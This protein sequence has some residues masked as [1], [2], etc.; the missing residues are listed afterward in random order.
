V[1]ENLEEDGIT[2]DCPGDVEVE[3]GGV[4]TC[5]ATSTDGAVAVLELTQTDDAGAVEWR[6]VDAATEDGGDEA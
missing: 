2:V 3:Q 4:F 6:F 5:T 1:E